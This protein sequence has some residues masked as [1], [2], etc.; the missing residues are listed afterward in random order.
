[1][2]DSLWN[3]GPTPDQKNSA[4]Y[5]TG[6]IGLLY[7]TIQPI[8][9][10]YPLATIPTILGKRLSRPASAFTL[11]GAVL[12]YCLKDYDDK[13]DYEKIA[14]NTLR[15]GLAWGS[16][17]HLSLVLMKIIGVDGGG[18]VFPGR[19][20]WEVYPAMIAVPFAAAVSFAVYAMLCF[21]AWTDD[22]A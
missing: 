18:L 10:P 12:A 22:D 17:A 14:H 13:S 2:I 20:L 19:G 15:K 21:G 6:A 11:L 7:F 5:A 8:V 16:A 3:L 9:S 4:L 1:M